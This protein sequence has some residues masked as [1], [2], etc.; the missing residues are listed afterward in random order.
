MYFE[1]GQVKDKKEEVRGMREGGDAEWVC[2]SSELP[3]AEG[4]SS[5]LNRGFAASYL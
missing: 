2:G 1:F 3:Q 4:A 5:R